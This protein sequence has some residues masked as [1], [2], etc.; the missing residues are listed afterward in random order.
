MTASGSEERT[1]PDAD[2][3]E[4]ASSA[5]STGTSMTT[6]STTIAL[7]SPRMPPTPTAV[8]PL[9]TPTPSP[10]AEKARFQIP[11]PGV[12]VDRPWMRSE[13]LSPSRFSGQFFDDGPSPYNLADL[14]APRPPYARSFSDTS[15]MSSRFSLLPDPSTWGSAMDA[16]VAEPDDVL[17][18]PDPDRD[19]TIDKGGTICTPRGTLNLGCLILLLVSLFAL[20]TAWPITD[21]FTHNHPSNL[22]NVT[23][24]STG[25]VPVDA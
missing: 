15:S 12:E 9:V 21:H 23:T 17:H 10:P 20:F 11:I 19:K 6:S 24:N 3:G 7:S 25:Q 22:S 1:Q 13:L 8:T 14:E 18:T 5:S 16:T 2:N 4:G